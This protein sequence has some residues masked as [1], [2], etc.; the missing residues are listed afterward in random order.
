MESGKYITFEGQEGGG[1][2]TQ[3][4]LLSE[5]LKS[6]HI[7][8][9]QVR[10]PGG[11]PMAEKMRGILL[12][13]EQG[14]VDLTGQPE[15]IDDVSEIFAFMFARRQLVSQVILPTLA[16]GINVLGDRGRDSTTAYQGAGR[17]G[18]NAGMM[19]MIDMM[20]DLATGNQK[21]DRT[22]VLDL[23]VDA[24][25]KRIMTRGNRKDRIE[26]S[27]LDFFERVR[28]QF[29][30][31]AEREPKRVVVI[32]AGQSLKEV[33]EEIKKHCDKLFNLES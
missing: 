26:Q 17:F 12:S 19:A 14:I 13:S 8:F 5:H 11:T 25:L 7:P 29:L 27:G 30:A 2:T 18:T 31:I 10:E 33:F 4:S 1:K 15:I 20:N 16:H 3:M 6:H 9:I 21:P 24:M 22:F 23:S 28:K 32:D